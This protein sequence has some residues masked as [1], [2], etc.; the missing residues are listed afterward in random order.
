MQLTDSH[1]HLD[2]ESFAN[3]RKEV[4]DRARQAGVTN[5]VVPAVDRAS[6]NRIAALQDR[7]KGVHAAYG[8]HPMFLNQHRPEHLDQLPEWLENHPAVAIGEIGLDYFVEGLDAE[9]QRHYF[10]SQL[11]IARDLKLPVIVHARRAVDEV[12]S[13]IRQMGGLT[14]VVH[15]F[16]GSQ[17]Q[18]EQLWKAGFL[19]GLGG[20]LTYERAQ[21]LRRIVTD[22]PLE[23]L[24]LETDAPDQPGSNHRG[25][26]NEPAHIVDVLQTVASL[27]NELPDT[28]A[29][30]TTNNARRLFRFP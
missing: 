18:A 22:M 15:S 20:P 3:D 17:Q 19:I 6:W 30:A 10:Q 5:I 27:R 28:I 13:S 24:L 14:G 29:E 25:E 12:I 1:A 11:A 2:D 21:R 26:R 4:I 23:Y 16:S 7:Q 8:M 9:K